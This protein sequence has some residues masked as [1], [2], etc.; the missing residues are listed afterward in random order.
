MTICDKWNKDKLTN[1]ETNRKIKKDGPTYNKLKKK[2]S[3]KKSKSKDLDCDKWKQDWKSGK[4]I[5][6]ETLYHWLLVLELHIE[7]D[8]LHL[9]L[10]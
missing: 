9:F 1:P 10:D 5:N 3:D 2:C 7:S 6:P 8:T 4:K